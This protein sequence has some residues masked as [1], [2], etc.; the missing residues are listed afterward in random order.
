[1]PKTT[2]RLIRLGDAKRLT[3]GDFGRESEIGGVLQEPAA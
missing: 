3:R 2:F 1:M